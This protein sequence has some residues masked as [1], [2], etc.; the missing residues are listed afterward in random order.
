MDVGALL[1]GALLEVTSIQLCNNRHL[2][3]TLKISS[4]FGRPAQ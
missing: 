1:E 3:S 2:N 4:D